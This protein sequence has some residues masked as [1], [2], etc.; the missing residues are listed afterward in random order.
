VYKRLK[1]LSQRPLAFPAGGEG[2]FDTI[3][4]A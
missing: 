2:C 3:A 1:S 4:V